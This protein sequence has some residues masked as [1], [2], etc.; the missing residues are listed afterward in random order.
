MDR[1]KIRNTE[2]KGA[3]LGLWDARRGKNL[4][5][6]RAPHYEY[7][8]SFLAG[9]RRGQRMVEEELLMAS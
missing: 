4:G 2:K 7:P 8:A 9:Y 3:K 6:D 1:E 5:D